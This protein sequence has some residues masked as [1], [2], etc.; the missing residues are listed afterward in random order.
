MGIFSQSCLIR[1]TYEDLCF[2][3]SSNLPPSVSDS[4]VIVMQ[5][6][7]EAGQNLRCT[8][9]FCVKYSH[10]KFQGLHLTT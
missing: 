2:C 8:I 1:E 7:E 4:D 5:L 3:V 9:N 6:F 10:L